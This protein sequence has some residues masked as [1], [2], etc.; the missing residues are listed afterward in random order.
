MIL[1]GVKALYQSSGVPVPAG[2]SRRVSLLSAPEQLTELIVEIWPKS[3]AKPLSSQVLEE[4]LVHGLLSNVPGGAYLVSAKERKVAEQLEGNRYVGI[5]IALAMDDGETILRVSR[6]FEG[7]PAGAYK[8]DDLIEAVDGTDTKGMVLRDVVSR[9][10]GDEGTGVIVTVRQPKAK[11]S[12]TLKM[13]RASLPRTTFVRPPYPE[14]F[15]VGTCGAMAAPTQSAIFD[16]DPIAAST[17][18]ELRY[19]ARQLENDGARSVP[20]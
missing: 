15:G 19:L 13:T 20:P 10:R 6:I 12:R 2:L 16:I 17:P 18:H 4:A 7:G 11:E 14:A 8:T 1:G 5:Q 9:L 3:M